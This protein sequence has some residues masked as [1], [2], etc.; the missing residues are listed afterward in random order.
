MSAA[1]DPGQRDCAGLVRFAYREALRPR[2]V[3]QRQALKL[4]APLSLP[5]VTPAVFGIIPRWPFIWQTSSAGFGYFAD[6]DTLLRYGFR[7]HSWNL[8]KAKPG[9][10]LVYFTDDAY[11][12]WG[13]HLMMFAGGR[14]R[15]VVVYH[16]GAT[17]SQGGVR[18]VEVDNLAASPEPA[19]QPTRQNPHFRG[20]YR[21]RYFAPDQTPAMAVPPPKTHSRLPIAEVP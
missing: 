5:T 4:P 15:G 12:L 19:W 7:F 11:G 14:G 16:N 6:S 17:G 18:V 10:L 2:T 20:I 1:W 3:S 9:D 21:W 8:D 13:K